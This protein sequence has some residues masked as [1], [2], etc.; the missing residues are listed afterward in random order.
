MTQLPEMSRAEEAEFWRTHDATDYLDEFAS[1]ELTKTPRPDNHCFQCQK[2]MR[3]RYVN[4]E[5]ALG[6]A[7]IRDLRE[8]YCPDG[9]EARLS[10]EAQRLVNA[11]EAVLNLAASTH[12]ALL[13]D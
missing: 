12:F 10:P 5:I 11:I 8:L 7:V 2:V 9:H 3:S 6:R 1:V 4:V 13:V